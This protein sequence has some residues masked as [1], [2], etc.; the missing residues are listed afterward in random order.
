MFINT[1]LVLWAFD[2]QE[3]REAPI[4][5]MALADGATIHPLPFKVVFKPRM[6]N[7]K[8]MIESYAG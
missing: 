5:G 1:A 6:E 7:L 2:V 3:V 8:A 4:D